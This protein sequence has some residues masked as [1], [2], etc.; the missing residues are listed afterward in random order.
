MGGAVKAVTKV[1]KNPLKA[2]KGAV[3]GAVAG[4]TGGLGN[5]AAQAAP[6]AAPAAAVRT[7]TKTVAP[8]PVITPQAAISAGGG[9]SASMMQADV[10]S[11]SMDTARSARSF[12]R[13]R[14]KGPTGAYAGMT[15]KKATLG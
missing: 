6:Q 5:A 2:I 15:Q 8:K 4:A 9:P 7:V 14:K 1:V 10:Q 11:R 13:T 12:M 3:G